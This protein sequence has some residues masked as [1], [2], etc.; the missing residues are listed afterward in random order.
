MR[1]I[2]SFI[3]LACVCGACATAGNAPQ[4]TPEARTDY[5]LK[6]VVDAVGTLQLAAEEATVT[7]DSNG[8]P[9][10]PVATA[11][12]IVQ[13]CVDADDVLAANHSGWC[14]LVTTSYRT[15]KTQLSYSDLN[16]ASTWFTTFEA[17][18][19]T[20]GCTVVQNGGVQ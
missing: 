11:R 19:A 20:Q 17:A 18:L 4:L 16:T 14:A 10:L 2:S 8:N 5:N 3:V 15:L 7:K 1:L 13:F 9:L 12:R 6:P